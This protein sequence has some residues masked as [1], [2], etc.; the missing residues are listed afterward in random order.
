M[1]FEALEPRAERNAS[2]AHAPARRGLVA[3]L[4]KQEPRRPGR[5]AP[6][7]GGGEPVPGNCGSRKQRDRSKAR[8]FTPVLALIVLMLLPG[9]RGHAQ[10]SAEG[11]SEIPTPP[12]I[13]SPASDP[14]S[15]A[16]VRA[17][18]TAFAVERPASPVALRQLDAW[19]D[20]AIP[21]L[22]ELARSKF[23]AEHGK[24]L[25]H[26]I[27]RLKT[28]AACDLLVDLLLGDSHVNSDIVLRVLSRYMT[29][30][31]MLECLRARDDLRSFL[32]V[33]Q[34]GKG[35]RVRRQCFELRRALGKPRGLQAS[36]G[37]ERL[38]L[39]TESMLKE[40]VPVAARLAADELPSV[41]RVLTPAPRADSLVD[42]RR[43]DCTHRGWFSGDWMQPG[44]TRECL[45]CSRAG[46]EQV[47]DTELRISFG[48]ESEPPRQGGFKLPPSMYS[49]GPHCYG[50]WFR[51]VYIPGRGVF[52]IR[53]LSGYAIMPW[54]TIYLR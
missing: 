29:Q 21:A 9:S 34:V 15:R 48:W 30:P 53:E 28:E 40:R 38:T 49:Y 54:E 6:R 31:A 3:L 50:G 1:E 35:A 52:S 17:A 2:R 22:G 42:P 12:T 51:D 37:A 4:T 43:I 11:T 20:L 5:G 36:T 7:N 8:R 45:F 39:S 16:E 23:G 10:N 24:A 32:D 19:G 18:V 41:A 47:C 13:E 26:C 14:P 25:A 33:Y 27:Q 44:L 46:E